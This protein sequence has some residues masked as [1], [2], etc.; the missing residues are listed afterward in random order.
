MTNTKILCKTWTTLPKTNG[1]K[2]ILLPNLIQQLQ[3]DK[4]QISMLQH[5]E[6][7]PNQHL[8]LELAVQEYMK[9]WQIKATLT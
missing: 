3:R 1:D 9:I 4:G 7:E 8:F 5:P 2:F 6:T